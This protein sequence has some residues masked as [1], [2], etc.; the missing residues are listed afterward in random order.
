MAD[1]GLRFHCFHDGR[2]TLSTRIIGGILIEVGVFVTTVVLAMVDSSQWPGVFFWI[3]MVS[4]VVLNGTTRLSRSR[5][6][7]FD[8]TPFSLVSLGS[9]RRHLPEHGLRSGRQTSVQV[10]GRRRFG[11]GSYGQH[12]V[13]HWHVFL[14]GFGVSLCPFGGTE[15]LRRLH[16]R[17]QHRVQV[18]DH[19]R[20]HGGH[21]LLHHGPLHPFGLFRHLLRP[22][23]QR[24]LLFLRLFTV[25]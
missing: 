21:L 16:G 25:S 20:P 18:R 7:P 6:D 22:A 5:V 11:I 13:A 23:A 19:Q 14:T 1:F 24:N 12:G 17:R 3:T 15:H 2:G 9:G 4:V 10:H 8:S